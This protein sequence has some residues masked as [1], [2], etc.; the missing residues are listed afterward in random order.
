MKKLM[1]LLLSVLM[2]ISI[3]MPISVFA[4]NGPYPNDF[5]N[6]T[7]ED[8]FSEDF[9]MSAVM[10][11]DAT[12]AESEDDYDSYALGI[13]YP[14]LE[15][16]EVPE[17]FKGVTYDEATNTV[18]LNNVRL[19]HTSLGLL[20][21]GDDFKIKLVGYNELGCISSIGM[22]WGAS[23]TL[24]GNGELVL[25]KAIND[26]IY[27][28]IEIYADETAAFFCAEKDVNL[29][30]YSEPEYEELAIYVEGST[31]TDPSQ[32]IQ[33]KGTVKS[34]SVVSELY[35]VEFFEKISAYDIFWNTYDYCD[36]VYKKAETGDTLY[37]A[38][39]DYDE[40]TYEPNGKYYITEIAYDEVLQCYAGAPFEED[41]ES[42]DPAAEGYT[43][44]MDG[45]IPAT[46][47]NI[48]IPE[49]KTDY[50]LAL[51][52]DGTVKY[53]FEKD[54]Y[55]DD[56]YNEVEYAV[57]YNM[58]EHPE[59]GYIAK[60]IP[61]KDNLDGLVPQKIGEKQYCDAYIESTV[62]MNRGGSVAPAA[63]SGI[64][65][66]NA[67]DGVKVSWTPLRNASKYRVYRKAAGDKSWTT[68]TTLSGAS[69]SSYVDKTAK[70]GVKYTY[71]VKAGNIV[72]WGDYNKTG[73][74]LTY[75]ASPKFTAAPTA[76]GMK[77]SWGKVNGAKTYRVY[78]KAAGEADFTKLADVTSLSFTD[79]AVKNGKTY[80]YAVRALNG[81]LASGY[82]SASSL[83]VATP[84]LTAIANSN[85]G[86]KV[87]WG[88]VSGAD[89]YIV[90]RK[91]ASSDWVV[92]GKTNASTVAFTDKTAKSGTTYIYTV[93]AVNDGVKSGYNANGISIKYLAAPTFKVANATN[94]VKVSW[95][96]VGGAKAYRI[97]RKA[98]GEKAYT[99]LADVTSLSFT[100][101]TAKN[102]KTYT[103]AVR[104]LNGKAAS[105][106]KAAAIKFVATPKLTAI[107]NTNT[108]INVA[109]GKVSGATSYRVYRKAAGKAGWTKLADT[110]KLNY[111]DKTAQAGVTYTYTVK[112][113][114]G[115]Y[116]GGYDKIGITIKK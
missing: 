38:F 58:I 55:Y 107:K 15:G 80:T 114:N 85:A 113:Y 21:M 93:R 26:S 72:G 78:R 104:A 111:T 57:V 35:T 44:V 73:V 76:T 2:I 40:E 41:E 7:E 116:A 14:M 34:S 29:K 48:F 22:E 18:T 9:K 56:D 39:E 89:G 71:T 30:I 54:Y 84:K 59:Y 10:L 32:L 64:K 20:A 17:M 108:G 67:K 79:K 101:K 91:T 1:C 65:V 27:C 60:E 51:S 75:L 68:L 95:S 110:T 87:T 45:S 69:T 98:E 102:G 83:F 8:L 46:I 16:M 13:L 115:N 49:E 33:F 99:K 11:I 106:Y 52:E 31:I 92:L 96:K 97:Y 37:A 24:I 47:E 81:K 53:G 6:M 4:E 5:E 25:N 86:V 3:L 36:A 88:K 70:S 82:K 77:I 90:Y 100:D 43:L 94:G 42:V 23:V 103:Y 66:A 50:D 12:P 112:A 62:T 28:G 74:T 63:V 105:S 61:D 19:P 109:W